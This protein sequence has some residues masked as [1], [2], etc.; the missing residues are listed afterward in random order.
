MRQIPL[1]PFL[2]ERQVSSVPMP[3]EL[4]S[5]TPVTTTLR[6]KTILPDDAEGGGL[7]AALLGFDVIDRVFHSLDF[8]GVLVR[9][10]KIERLFEGHDQF[11]DVERIRSEVV[12][13]GCRVVHLILIYAKLFDNNLLHLLLN[14]HEPS[15]LSNKLLILA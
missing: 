2:M 1:C 8:L 15:K 3:T 4:R 12:N 9:N 14:R 10:I 7:L 5:P 11:Y 6:G 13:E